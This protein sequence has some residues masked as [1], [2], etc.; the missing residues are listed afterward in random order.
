MAEKMQRSVLIKIIGYSAVIS[1]LVMFVTLVLDV[2][3]P[4]MN[5]MGHACADSAVC[6]A[7]LGTREVSGSDVFCQNFAFANKFKRVYILFNY[8]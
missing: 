5:F 1:G 6:A 2:Y 3:N 8:L 7:L 4:F